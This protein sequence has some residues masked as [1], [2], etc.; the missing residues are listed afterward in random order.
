[1]RAHRR[2]LS[3]DATQEA[4][5]QERICFRPLVCA[6]TLW[7]GIAPTDKMLPSKHDLIIV[8]NDCNYPWNEKR[9]QVWAN[10][11]KSFPL[12]SVLFYVFSRPHYLRS[13]QQ[14]RSRLLNWIFD[15]KCLHKVEPKRPK[16]T[17]VFSG[18]R[19]QAFGSSGQCP[20]ICCTPDY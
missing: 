13:Y 2:A 12:F 17:S 10:I 16:T 11:S 4:A 6:L 3:S 20:F 8:I 5:H 1:M 14:C 18:G 7:L 15:N 19:A 9:L